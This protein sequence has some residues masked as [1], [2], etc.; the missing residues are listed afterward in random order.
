MFRYRFSVAILI[1]ETSLSMT[2]EVLALNRDDTARHWASSASAASS[3]AHT[4][5]PR[6]PRESQIQCKPLSLSMAASRLNST[7]TNTT[8]FSD[9]KYF[10]RYLDWNRLTFDYHVTGSQSGTFD[11]KKGKAITTDIYNL[12]QELNLT[13]LYGCAPQTW[14]LS[15]QPFGAP[16]NIYTIL[17]TA[18]AETVINASRADTPRL[19]VLNTG[20]VRF[21]LIKGP[22][23]YD[24]SFIVNP[25]HDTF[26]F[27]PNVPY[28]QAK[29]VLPTLNRGA[30]QKR[31]LEEP[32]LQARD[33]HFSQ[34]TG[35]SCVDSATQI[36]AHNVLRRSEPM[37]RGK[38]KRQTSKLTPGYVTTDDFGTDGDDTVHSKIPYYLQPNDFQANASFP[39]DGSTPATVDLVFL[40]FIAPNVLSALKTTGASYTTADVQDYLPPSFDTNAY[41][42]A[43]AK[44]AWQDNVPNCPVGTGVGS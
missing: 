35:E 28:A 25:F 13:A 18:L 3:P 8:K 26:Q 20:S 5:E 16:G 41:L 4:R 11:T 36:H 29:T 9:L 23:T 19:I 32:Q 37:T 44:M 33:F 22:F 38:F 12:R 31:S 39:T 43:Y 1:S 10:R 14:C 7:T 40:D 21:D 6:T 24:D 34:L 42:P 2:M 15:C 17:S 30:Y 27:L